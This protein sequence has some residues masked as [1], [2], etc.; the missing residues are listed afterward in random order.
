MMGQLYFCETF[1]LDLLDLQKMRDG[2]LDLVKELFNPN[3]IIALIQ[4]IFSPQAKQK[5]IH[6][7]CKSFLLSQGQKIPL[8]LPKFLGDGRR[9]K[10][11]L[12]NL[13]RNAIKFTNHGFIQVDVAYEIGVCQL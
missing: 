12:I 2:K 8:T 7:S 10:Q 5:K 13:V 6:L 4:A 3:E 9:F 1:A 11:C